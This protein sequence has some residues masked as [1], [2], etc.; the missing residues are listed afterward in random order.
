[1]F[2]RFCGGMVAVTG[3]MRAS[4]LAMRLGEDALIALIGR[5]AGIAQFEDLV[6]G[7]MPAELVRIDDDEPDDPVHLVCRDPGFAR[8]RAS[9]DERVERFLAFERIDEDRDLGREAQQQ[10]VNIGGILEPGLAIGDRGH[11]IGTLSASTTPK[12]CSTHAATGHLIGPTAP[13]PCQ[14]AT[15]G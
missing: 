15:G 6:L 10:R 8:A 7:I 9:A 12:R 14:I 5:D 4:T 3:T 13:P 11:A 1:M 2:D